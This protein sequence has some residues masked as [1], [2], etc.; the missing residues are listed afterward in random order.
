M[1]NLVGNTKYS[2]CDDGNGILADGEAVSLEKLYWMGLNA[3]VGLICFMGI[4]P[5]VISFLII[6]G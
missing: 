6:V 5:F 4:K 2:Y 1:G 3:M